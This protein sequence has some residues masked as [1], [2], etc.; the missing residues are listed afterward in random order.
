[1]KAKSQLEWNMIF[2]SVCKYLKGTNQED[3]IYLIAVKIKQINKVRFSF[4]ILNLKNKKAN[5]K[6]TFWYLQAEHVRMSIIFMKWK[7]GF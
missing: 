6:L 4:N 2:L 7:L 3:S 1:M 5:K